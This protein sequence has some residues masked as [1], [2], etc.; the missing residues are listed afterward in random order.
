MTFPFPVFCPSVDALPVNAAFLAENGT[1]A[2]T[3]SPSA[4]VNIGG[5]G[6]SRRLIIAV[7]CGAVTQNGVTLNGQ[8]ATPLTA[9]ITQ[10]QRSIRFW[11]LD[12]TLSGSVTAAASLSGTSTNTSWAVFALD[13]LTATL[14]DDG[15]SGVG[16][17]TNHSANVN[18]PANGCV[19][20]AAC[21]GDSSPGTNTW[22]GATEDYDRQS[23]ETSFVYSGAH[24]NGL[25]AET[26][27]TITI[28]NTQTISD[29]ALAAVSFT[30]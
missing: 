15:G 5:S 27:R 22:A 16:L 18:V 17:A 4:S 23:S 13:S 29:I 24:Q 6:E 3:S 9:A 8:A 1:T 11:Q 21:L 7:S 19:I 30:G 25:S 14:F 2:D 20:A 28:T 10:G 26:G 12:T